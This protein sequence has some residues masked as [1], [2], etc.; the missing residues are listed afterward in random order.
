[1]IRNI[2]TARFIFQKL[3]EKDFLFEISHNYVDKDR[4]LTESIQRL[5]IRNKYRVDADISNKI[6]YNNVLKM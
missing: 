3:N 5:P 1:M 6:E 4:I 2:N